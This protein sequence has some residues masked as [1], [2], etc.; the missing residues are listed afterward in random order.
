MTLCGEGS[1]VNVRVTVVMGPTVRPPS[2]P[3]SSC[4]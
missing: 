4:L 2:K 1:T 3:V